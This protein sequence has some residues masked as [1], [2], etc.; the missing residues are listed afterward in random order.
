MI[1]IF[2]FLILELPC[3]VLCRKMCMLEVWPLFLLMSHLYNKNVAVILILCC[4]SRNKYGLPDE[5]PF[6]GPPRS[7][8]P[9]SAVE[10]QHRVKWKMRQE[11]PAA[12][13]RSRIS[14]RVPLAR[15]GRIDCRE[16][17]R[18]LP[19]LRRNVDKALSTFALWIQSNWY[20]ST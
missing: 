2:L 6:P 10:L 20:L 14:V 18:S 17:C 8:R 16:V 11:S 9:I 15:V 7:H 19:F 12:R 4:S 13:T 1:L 5:R 3:I